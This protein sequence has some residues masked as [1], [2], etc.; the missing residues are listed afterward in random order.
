MDAGKLLGLSVSILLICGCGLAISWNIGEFLS[1]WNR[2]I[3]AH[4]W[5]RWKARMLKHPK[6]RR[7]K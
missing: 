3:A 6:I 5:A 4:K 7:L 2:A 1:Y